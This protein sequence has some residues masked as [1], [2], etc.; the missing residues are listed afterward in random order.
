[1]PEYPDPATIAHVPDRDALARQIAPVQGGDRRWMQDATRRALI[2]L[3]VSVPAFDAAGL[4]MS[5]QAVAET[6]TPI[7]A[8][9]GR[10]AVDEALAAATTGQPLTDGQAGW[11]SVLLTALPVRDY[12]WMHTDA[13]DSHAQLWT[14]LTRRAQPNLAAG[15]ACLLAYNA[16]LRGDGGLA[17]I[18]LQRAAQADPDYSMAQL[19]LGAIDRG[20][21]LRAIRDAIAVAVADEALEATD[22]PVPD[23]DGHTASGTG[24]QP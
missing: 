4:P 20:L 3:R 24:S 11:L 7:V 9:L 8:R 21:S 10:K 1:V 15:P 14:D 18:A 13:S 19:L 5:P 17:T 6:A 2:R 22:E 12:A 16:L 23:A